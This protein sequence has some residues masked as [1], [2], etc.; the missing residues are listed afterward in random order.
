MMSSLLSSTLGGIGSALLGTSSSSSDLWAEMLACQTVQDNIIRRFDLMKLYDDE[1]IED[2][3]KDLTKNVTITSSKQG[4]VYITVED[5]DPKKS[6]DMAN[7]FMEELD[8]INKRVNAGSGSQTRVFLGKRLDETKV[9]LAQA[10]EAVKAFQESNG[11]VQLDS[12][13]KAIIDAVGSVKGALMAKE[14]EL[15]T[16]L[17]YATPNNPQASALKS[18]IG[19]LKDQLRKL[20]VKGGKTTG[21]S[22]EDLFIPT[23]NIPG[24]AERYARLLREDKIQ[25]TLYGMLVSQYEQAR[26]QEANDRP[27]IALLDEAVVPTKKAKPKRVIIVGFATL[28]GI[29]AAVS[30]AFLLEYIENFK[31]SGRG[32]ERA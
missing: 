19:G 11:A 23:S 13:A 17:T 9:K 6:A 3:R 4:V 16:L 1:F 29:L 7:A 24:L 22:A 5:K 30:L 25:E 10:E 28:G 31:K 26:L 12:Q 20:G 2:A 14:V 15:N 32:G 21:K 8:R 27:T 18:E